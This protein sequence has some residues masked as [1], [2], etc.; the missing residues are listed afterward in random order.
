MILRYS[1]SLTT[2]FGASVIPLMLNL[3]VNPLIAMNM[4]PRDY[5]ISGYYSSFT[6]LISPLISFYLVG[7]YLKEYF[8]LD[9]ENRKDLY[10]TVAKALITLSGLIAVLCFL[11][12]A[13][14]LEVFKRDL[15]FPVMP[16]LGLMVF[17]IPLTGLLSLK[18]AKCRIERDTK[19]FF[20]YSVL[21][22]CLGVVSA[23]FFVVVLRLG[24]F[25]KL[26]APFICNLAIFL[27]LLV[28]NRKILSWKVGI[29]RYKMLILF[30]TPLV[31]G[32]MLEY[33]SGGFTNT[34]LESLGDIEEYGIYIVGASI[35]SYMMTFSWAIMHTF[36]PDIYESVTK[37]DTK[38][39]VRTVCAEMA[40]ICFGV[41]VFVV[42][43]PYIIDLLTAGRYTDSAPYARIIS[44]AAI[45]S[46][47]FYH[48]NDYAIIK[49]HRHIYLLTT[50]TGGIVIVF[51]MNV[52][53][54]HAGYIGGA[55]VN[56]LSFLIYC[57]IITGILVFSPKRHATQ[58]D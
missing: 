15:E 7:Y 30:C 41:I 53:T 29:E 34:Y 26:L 25:G 21:S 4:T 23:L 13:L 11:G 22:G 10:M 28:N 57:V 8:R 47:L 27:Y 54:S 20:R 48:A 6:S 33:F 3:L 46:V 19:G 16:Y 1:R 49:E 9:E 17:S 45:T 12:L 24:A 43:A 32:A 40:V 38:R 37:N 18:L 52:A 2:Y 55:W 42:C 5:A 31:L 56:V 39:L 44:V 35:G 51:A 58:R 36:Q 14:Y 50:V